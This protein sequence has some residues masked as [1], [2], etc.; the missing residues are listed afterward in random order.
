MARIEQFE[1]PGI[2]GLLHLPEGAAR[3]GLVLTHGAGGDCRAPLLVALAEAF[4]DAGL[5]V[6]RIDLPFRQRRPTG[7]PSPATAA[8]DRAGLA[9]AIGEMRA[10]APGRV[11]LGGHSYGGRQASGLAADAPGLAAALL[12]SSYPLHPPGRPERLRTAHFPRLQTPAVFVHGSAD[13]FGS[14]AELRTALALIPAPT[15][16]VAI[17]GA[18]HDLKRGRFD[19]VPV[20]AAALAV[21]CGPP[22]DGIS[23][24]RREA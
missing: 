11:L 21:R 3:G 9:A 1:K 16:L 5:A 6:L 10:L 22:A 17:D 13:P 23:Y 8:A 20:V 18:R 14:L 4:C 2:R 19:L 12:L 24:N 7:P 15:R